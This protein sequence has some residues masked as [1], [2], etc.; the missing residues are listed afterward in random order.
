MLNKELLKEKIKNSRI[1]IDEVA[2]AAE[3]D[4]STFYRRLA[5]D[6]CEFTI[7]EAQAISE[8]LGLKQRDVMAIFFSN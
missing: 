4:R 6:K 5:A 2:N 3:M 8:C 7:A 1:S